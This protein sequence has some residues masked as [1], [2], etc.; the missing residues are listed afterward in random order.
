MLVVGSEGQRVPPNPRDYFERCGYT[1]S[2]KE[3][4]VGNVRYECNTL[5]TVF[6]DGSLR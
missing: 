3:R 5:L 4:R 1:P 6:D 2:V